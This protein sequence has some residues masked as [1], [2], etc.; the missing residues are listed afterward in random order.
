MTGWI[1]WR[2]NEPDSTMLVGNG[3]WKSRAYDSRQRCFMHCVLEGASTYY[4]GVRVNHYFVHE[5]QDLI[6]PNRAETVWSAS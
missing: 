3:M 5:L 6:M 4:V 1:L 2:F